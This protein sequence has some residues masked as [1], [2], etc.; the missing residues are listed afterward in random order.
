M[1]KKLRQEQSDRQREAKNKA[2]AKYRQKLRDESSKLSPPDPS[3]SLPEQEITLPCP[4]HVSE[5]SQLL[6]ETIL[7]ISEISPRVPE[8]S[9]PISEIPPTYLRAIPEILNLSLKISLC[10][11]V[12]SLLCY[13]QAV[14]YAPKDSLEPLHWAIAIICEISLCYL[15]GSLHISWASR[16]LFAC[17]FSYNLAVM[18]YSIERDKTI[19]SSK[20][21]KEDIGEIMKQELFTKAK[22]AF[23]ISAKRQESGNVSK[24]LKTME[25]TAKMTASPEAAQMINVFKFEAVSLVILRAILMLLNALLIHRILTPARRG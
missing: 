21:I 2:N 24:F 25:D 10:I 12:T 6:P 11:S 8:I 7:P 22:T 13:F 5:I 20:E 15:S 3:S 19:K 16:S 23:D 4:Q 18:T 17:F 1:S 9:H 14:A